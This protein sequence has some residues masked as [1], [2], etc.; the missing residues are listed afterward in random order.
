MAIEPVVNETS[1]CFVGKTTWFPWWIFLCGGPTKM[2]VWMF[3]LEGYKS[4]ILA[5]PWWFGLLPSDS[6]KSNQSCLWFDPFF[7]SFVSISFE[8]PFKKTGRTEQLPVGQKNGGDLKNRRIRKNLFPKS[9]QRKISLWF[10]K[11][12]RAS[13]KSLINSC[14]NA[15]GGSHTS[16]TGRPWGCWSVAWNHISSTRDSTTKNAK[17]IDDSW[18]VFNWLFVTLGYT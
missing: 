12:F 7:Q 14:L 8:K 6:S 11:E 18:W 17:M 13:S 15:A 9:M 4:L 3:D 1:G 5:K 16:E 10:A 2:F